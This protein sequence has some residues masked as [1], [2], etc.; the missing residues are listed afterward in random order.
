MPHFCNAEVIVVHGISTRSFNFGP[1]FALAAYTSDE[2]FKKEG[3]YLLQ[4]GEEMHF[5]YRVLIHKGDASEADVRSQYLSFVS[6]PKVV[7]ESELG[8]KP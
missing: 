7:V 8:A 1:P 4:V 5:H 2:S 6:P 3:S